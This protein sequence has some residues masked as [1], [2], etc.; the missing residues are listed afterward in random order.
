MSKFWE[1]KWVYRLLSFVLALGIFFY[2]NT[3]QVNNTRQ[4]GTANSSLLATRS[5]TVKVPL[6]L[7]A[8]TT[9]Y[10]ITGYPQNVKV[11][12][13][14]SSALVTAVK[15][16]Q[17]F[18]VVANLSNLGVGKHKVKLTEEGLNQSLNYK[19]TPSTINVNIQKRVN[20]TMPIEV[21]YNADAL[22]EGYEVGTP[23]LSTNSAQVSGSRSE[24][25]RINK[26]VA[27]VALSHN[28]KKDVTQN[29]SVQA[30]DSNGNTLN[31]VVLPESVKVTLP[32]SLPSKKVDVEFKQSGTVAKDRVVAFKSNTD[33]VRI[34]GSRSVLAKIDKLTLPVD[35]S[36]VTSSTTKTVNVTDAYPDLVAADPNSIKVSLKV[37]TESSSE[38]GDA[39]SSTSESSSDS[40]SSQSVSSSSSSSSAK[41]SSSDSSSSDSSSSSS[42]K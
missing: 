25:K 18:R 1:S 33:S 12:V 8:D 36:G 41:S 16:T 6:Q 40:A 35:V 15:N 13:S 10:F 4:T 23:K 34:Y 19:I 27:T 30:V 11:R 20:K 32:V 26:V 3:K 9:K 31:V 21:K 37:T 29:V 5:A 7:N 42:A 24:I 17:N 28:T 14:G 38:A 22:A 2:V 39:S